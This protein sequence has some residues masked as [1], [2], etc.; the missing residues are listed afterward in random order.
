MKKWTKVLATSILAISLLAGC[1]S[2]GDQASEASA[3]KTEES[4]TAKIKVGVT[5]GPH[6]EVMEKVKEVAAKDGLEIEIVPFNDFV[7]PNKVLAEGELDANVFQHKPYLDQFKVDHNLDLIEIATSINFPMGIY[8]SKIKDV[9]ELKDGDEIGLPND[10]TNGARALML[11]EEAGWIKLKEGIGVK[12]TVQDIAEN[13]KNLK[14]KELEAAFI[15]QALDDLAA[16]AINTPFAMEH[17][18][19]PAKDSIFM[20]PKDSPW[21]N[22][23]VVR[24]EDKDRPEFKKLVQ[25]YQSAEVKAFIEEHFQGSVIPSW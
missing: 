12:A 22:L 2:S 3:P 16:A 7:Q 25:A 23:I 9:K 10:P 6:E 5:I 14:F 4:Q 24:T 18:F 1:G 8:S 20:E 15:P 11:F 13:P 21:M 19:T 17:G